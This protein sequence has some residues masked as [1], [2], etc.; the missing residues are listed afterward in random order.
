MR[1]TAAFFA[2]SALSGAGASSHERLAS[3]AYGARMNLPSSL[4]H[5]SLA[6]HLFSELSIV[7]WSLDG[8]ALSARSAEAYTHTTAVAVPYAWLRTYYP[9]V[10]DEYEAYEAVAKGKA[11]NGRMSRE[12]CYVVGLD[13][14]V[15]TNDFK[16]TSFPLKVDGTPDIEHIV[17]DPPQARWNVPVTYKVKGA[18]NLNDEDWPEVTEG[19]KGLF[20][21]FK[22]ELVLP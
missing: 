18:A 4:F 17:F 22:V 7:A 10:A 11:A 15:A 2:A 20:R 5:S 19:N 13:P 9:T 12:E 8:S 3:H 16:I 6:S 14:E 1:F 21:F